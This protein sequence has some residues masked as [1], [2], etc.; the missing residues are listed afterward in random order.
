[1]S[2]LDLGWYIDYQEHMLFPQST[3]SNHGRIWVW[4]EK[5]AI[6]FLFNFI[7][8]AWR[9]SMMAEALTLSSLE[10]HRA[11]CILLTVL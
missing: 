2:K 8:N 4:W 10:V 11:A 9:G 5:L 6:F 3:A 7:S 1:M